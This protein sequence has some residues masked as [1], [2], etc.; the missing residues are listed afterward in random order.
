V[1]GEMLSKLEPGEEAKEKR[2]K[3]EARSEKKG[4][5]EERG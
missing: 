4:E 1:L 3:T 2:N 5:V